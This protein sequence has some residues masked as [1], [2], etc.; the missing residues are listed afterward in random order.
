[1]VISSPYKFTDEYDKIKT[2]R[3]LYGKNE[4]TLDSEYIQDQD[5]AED[6]L[7]WV[8][9]KNLR[10][11]KAIGLNIFPIPTLQVGDMV[12][13]NYKDNEGVDVLASPDTRFVVYNIDYSK[14]VEGPNMTVYLSE[15]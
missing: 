11:R 9:Q 3:L 8:I 1:V 6:I 15:V 4:F 2:S 13:I 7:G 5:T 12:N 10:P 14:A